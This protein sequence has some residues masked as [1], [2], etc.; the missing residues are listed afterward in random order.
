MFYIH[1]YLCTVRCP[2]GGRL[3]RG[4]LIRACVKDEVGEGGGRGEEEGGRR[5]GGVKEYFGRGN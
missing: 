3:G 5:M 1:T 2:L 4:S